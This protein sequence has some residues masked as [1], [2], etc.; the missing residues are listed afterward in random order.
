LLESAVTGKTISHY[1]ILEKLGEG[2]MGA[3][4]KA[5]DTRLKRTVAIKFLSPGAIG[6]DEDRTRFIH[7]AQAAA[8]LNHPNI[9]TI[10]E[11]D[12]HGD[13]SFIA[14]EYIE[15]VS[16]KARIGSGPLQLDEAIEIAIEIAEGL[17]EAHTKGIIHRDIKSDNI[18]ITTSGRVRVMDF[19]L[20]KSS[21]RAQLTR[22]GTVVGTVAYMSPEQGRGEPVDHRTDIWSLGIVL[23]EM[24]T[25][26]LPFEAD[27]EQ[28][29]I[30]RIVNE[31]PPSLM[32]RRSD[33]PDELQ[34]IVARAL[35]KRAQDRYESAKALEEDLK[36]FLEGSGGGTSGGRKSAQEI[37]PSIAVLPFRDMS[38]QQDQA[39]FCEGIAEEL[40]NALVKI[41]GLRVAARTSSFQ[42][43]DRGTDIHK[44]GEQLNVTTVLEGSIRKAGDRLRITAQLIKV[45][46]G[47]HIWSEKY[48]R[49][50]DDIF[51]IQDEISLSIVDRL[52]VRLL[53]DERSALIKRHTID[54][55]AHS[56]YLKGLYFWNR[57]LEGGMRKALELFQQAIEKDPGYALAHVGIADVHTVT[58]FFG[59][60]SP[61]E[62][63]P[64]AKAAAEK[65][66]AIDGTL[67]EAH[68]SLAWATTCYDWDWP[69][70]EKL[71]ARAIDL[72]PQYAT[73]HEWYAIHLWA[74]GRFD[75]AIAEAERARELDPLSL[76]IN[77]I[78]GI[79]YY[80]AGRYDES[81]AN[82]KKALELD[83]NFLLAN[84]YL[85]MP[86][87]EE[88][89]Y[90][91][92]VDIM[93]RVESAAAEHAYSL[94]YF[95][96]AYGR[97]GLKDDALRILAKLDELARRR[98]VS[99][100]S[101]A[102]V[103]VGLDRF[104]EALDEMEKSIE[105]RFPPNVFS[106]T[107][108]FFD[109]LR[110]NERFQALLS[111]IGLK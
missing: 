66:L 34:R 50:L 51:A 49:D 40:I 33:V 29:T 18:M 26:E 36:S 108:P 69:S 98:Y 5:E 43:K 74:M 39:Y 111:K 110:S 41:E 19:G 2:G 78:V 30:Y 96:G 60:L 80:F 42:F 31:E 88:G 90:D 12:E 38:P 97:A 20:A 100:F 32:S 4:Y 95:G 105:E 68:A 87:V 86:Y 56:L 72:N 35:A 28:A 85:T 17:Q 14:M 104:D 61:S 73:A 81:I 94:G 55:E 47:F 79:A 76:I 62:T 3:V 64:K 106:G 6:A 24:I 63:F 70:A 99:P 16:L 46:D 7:E 59:Y 84:T 103:L 65:A 77:T 22:A 109:C 27:Y 25:G 75:E 53:R 10:Y 52:K 57:R 37:K 101:R 45:E 48:D 13:R 1:R 44:I 21:G 92:A 83:P 71:Y 15:G 11:I 9:C 8:A 23:H 107:F 67:G 58:G 82:H 93:R 89:K 54:Q 102:V 91:A